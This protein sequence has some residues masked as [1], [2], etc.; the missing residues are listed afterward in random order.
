MP[1]QKSL[2]TGSLR[3]DLDS[4]GP[5][6]VRV[7]IGEDVCLVFVA[8]IVGPSGSLT[9][10]VVRAA[11][12]DLVY[13]VGPGSQ[14]RQGAGV[15]APGLLGLISGRLNAID[16]LP[17]ELLATWLRL[18]GQGHSRKERHREV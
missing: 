1:S 4:L 12:I 17:D 9:F 5:I 7:R 6:I 3:R 16:E 14:A 10:V 8:G 2:H 11:S 13:K 15:I 18:R